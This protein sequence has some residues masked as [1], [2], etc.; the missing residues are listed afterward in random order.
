MKILVVDDNKD[1]A[2]LIVKSLGELAEETTISETGEAA[3]NELQNGQYDCVI[4]DYMLPDMSGLEVLQH[5][6]DSGNQS[7][8]LFV[9]GCD[10]KIIATKSIQSGAQNYFPKDN[11]QDETELFWECVQHTAN[12]EYMEATARLS[13]ITAQI[14]LINKKIDAIRTPKFDAIS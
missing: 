11:I 10:D 3:I 8:I 14:A 4:L 5:I 6:R 7:P 2:A 13:L 1:D 12:L 9:T